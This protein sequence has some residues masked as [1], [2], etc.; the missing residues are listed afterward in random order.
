[1]PG[2]SADL[3]ELGQRLVQA[4]LPDIVK[5]LCKEYPELGGKMPDCTGSDANKKSELVMPDAVLCP[6]GEVNRNKLR[7]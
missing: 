7:F 6:L 5:Q 3:I 2:F 1:M 4:K